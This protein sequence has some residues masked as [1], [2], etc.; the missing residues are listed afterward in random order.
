[1]GA[2]LRVTSIKK[3]I[4]CNFNNTDW[5]NFNSSKLNHGGKVI[6]LLYFIIAGAFQ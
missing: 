3:K 2:S 6:I 4:I 5:H 1:M